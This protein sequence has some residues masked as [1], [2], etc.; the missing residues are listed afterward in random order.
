MMI[1]NIKP[2]MTLKELATNITGTFFDKF[3]IVAEY[4][5]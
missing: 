1:D 3:I 5:P 2:N 4:E